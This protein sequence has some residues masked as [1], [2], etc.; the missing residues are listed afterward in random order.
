ME[1][2]LIITIVVCIISFSLLVM[3]VFIIEDITKL[4][5]EIREDAERNRSYTDDYIRA[6]RI[7]YLII[8]LFTQMYINL[9]KHKL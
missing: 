9:L 5:K 2:L 6:E 7:K 3:A 8:R 4:R 1:T